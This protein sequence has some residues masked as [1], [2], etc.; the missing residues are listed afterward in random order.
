MASIIRGVYVASVTPFTASGEIDLAALVGHGKWLASRGVQGIVFFGTNGEGPS[1]ALAEKRRALEHLFARGWSCQIVPAVMEGNLP[2]TVELVR[3][4]ADLPAAAVLVLPPYYFKPPHHDGLRRF[5]EPVL[6]AARQ[7]VILYHIPKYAVSVP[8]ELV[9]ALDVWGVKDSGGER[10][11]AEAVRAAGKNVLVGTEDD[12]WP[13]LTTGAAG[14]ISAL[15]NAVP[16]RILEIYALA[17]RGDAG[18]GIPLSQRLQQ[19]RALTKEYAAPAVLKRLAEAR[20]GLPMGS[21]RPPL[22]PAPE[23]YDPRPILRLAGFG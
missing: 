10:G 9:A 18:A 16:E 20:H 23:G 2:E 17:Q 11:Y 12:L 7:P 5:F 13:R 1:I 8:P 6:A 14:M 4:I 22:L 21:V 19:I 15:A 3:A